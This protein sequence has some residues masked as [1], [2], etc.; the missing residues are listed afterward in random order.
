MAARNS[1]CLFA[2]AASAKLRVSTS[3]QFLS[4]TKRSCFF[5]SSGLLRGVLRP[6]RMR[7]VLLCKQHKTELGLRAEMFPID[8]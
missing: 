2:K 1:R 3:A 6:A 4:R 7:S 5:L 8:Q